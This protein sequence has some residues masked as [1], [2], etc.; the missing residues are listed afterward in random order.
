VHFV[1][2]KTL[3]EAVASSLTELFSPQIISERLAGMLKSYDFVSADTLAYFSQRPPL[4]QRDSEFALDY[5]KRHATT[6]DAQQ[7]VLKALE[8]KCDAL[9]AMLD[10]LYHAYVAPKHIPP[11]AFVPK[12]WS[13]S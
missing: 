1:R 9:W 3:L 2:E 13:S 6:P 4:A 5:V 7:A 12:D 10:A 11:G 8:F